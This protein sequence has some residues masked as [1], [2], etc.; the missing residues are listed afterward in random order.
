MVSAD[1]PNVTDPRAIRALAHPVRLTIMEYL[2]ARDSATATEC[3][4]VV[5]LSPS[6]TSYHLR[7][8]ARYGLVEEAPGADRRE[9]RW[10]SVGR[11]S[12]GQGGG[13]DPAVRDATQLLS[14]LMIGRSDEKAQRFLDASGD[15]DPAWWEASVLSESRVWLTADELK[16]LSDALVDLLRPYGRGRRTPPEGAREVQV[17]LRAFPLPEAG[18]SDRTD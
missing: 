13:A 5:G 12:V 17:S 2:G 16:E 7:E 9:R 4:E 6:A 18:K 8:L 3:A 10:R 1:S 11:F 14:R 15:E